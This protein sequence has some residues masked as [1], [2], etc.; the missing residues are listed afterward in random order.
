MSVEVP[1]TT[2]F[3]PPKWLSKAEKLAF[4]RMVDARNSGGKPVLATDVD[5][6]ADLC[7]MRTRLADL[8]KMFREAV[9]DEREAGTASTSQRAAL[10]IARQLDATTGAAHRM[11]RR[12]GLGPSDV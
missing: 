8:R 1:E 9:R 11:A 5:P 10:A 6:I 2:S 7:A 3:P 12:L 4:R